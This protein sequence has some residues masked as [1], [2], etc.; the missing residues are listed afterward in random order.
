MHAPGLLADVASSRRSYE[1]ATGVKI[2]NQ[3]ERDQITEWAKQ[4]EQAPTPPPEQQPA[5]A[6]PQEAQHGQTPETQ[7]VQGQQAQ[8]TANEGGEERQGVLTPAAQPGAAEPQPAAPEKPAE[9]PPP[10]KTPLA[11]SKEAPRAQGQQ[12]AAAGK[13]TPEAVKYAPLHELPEAAKL[14]M[15]QWA[16]A[17]LQNEKNP[18]RVKA[19]NKIIEDAGK[20]VGGAVEDMKETLAKQAQGYKAPLRRDKGPGQQGRGGYKEPEDNRD[21][22]GAAVMADPDTRDQMLDKSIAAVRAGQSDPLADRIKELLGTPLH[23]TQDHIDDINSLRD[24]GHTEANPEESFLQPTPQGKPSKTQFPDYGKQ[25]QKTMLSRG[26]IPG[27]QD[28]FNT[29][30][31]EPEREPASDAPS[32]YI[33]GVSPLPPGTQASVIPIPPGVEKDL[34]AAAGVLAKVWDAVRATFS[35]TGI[36]AESKGMAGIV[37]ENAA[38][39]SKQH[40]QARFALGKFSKALMKMPTL[41]RYKFIDS[42]ETGSKIANPNMQKAADSIRNLLDEARDRVR[43]LGTG[44]LD[45]FITNYFP[46]IWK[47]PAKAQQVFGVGKRPLEGSKAFLKKRTIPTTRDGLAAGLEPITDN[48]IDL[49]LLKLHEVN[50]YVMAQKILAE[51][52]AAGY[53]KL[54]RSPGRQPDGWVQIDDKI[55]HVFQRQPTTT[56]SGKQGAPQY[57]HRGDY[58]AHPDAGRILNNY[59]SPGLRG[60][61]VYDAIRFAGNAMNMAQLGLSAFHVTG[62]TINSIVSRTGL[63]AK[64]AFEGNPV[65]GLAMAGKAWIAPVDALIG[66]SRVIREALQPGSQGQDFAQIVDALQAGGHRLGQDRMYRLGEEADT[67]WKGF[68][69]KLKEGRPSAIPAAFLAALEQSSRPMM[70]W[71]IPRMKQGVMLDMA[72]YELSKMPSNATRTDLR[73]TMREVVDSVDNRLGQLIYDNLFWN[74]TMKDVLMIST[75]S[76][77]WNLGTLRELAGGARDI[78]KMGTNLIQGKRPEL[79]HAASYAIALPFVVGILGAGMNYLYTGHGPQ[80]LMDLYHVPTGQKDSKGQDEK[81]Q[82]PTYM[83]DA[84]SWTSNFG[85]TLLS[86]THPLVAATVQALNNKDFYFHPIMNDKDPAVQQAIELAEYVGKQFVPF[87]I[88]NMLERPGKKGKIAREGTLGEKVESFIGITP[89]AQEKGK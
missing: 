50:R 39:L 19:L 9:P 56:A 69:N 23:D 57:V 81:V 35:P 54:F 33:P 10:K 55:G 2:S 47:D 51:G 34:N 78:A 66:G 29:E 84:F 14:A 15:Q 74:K 24:E 67:H 77:G 12:D 63:A 53:V 76:L 18:A 61:G 42:V 36:S 20:D 83:R 52:K 8:Q 16:Q 3:T 87:S 37:R 13:I 64:M 40:E 44:K 45:N 68:L 21:P 25:T 38:V 28:L 31:S 17:R 75:R 4:Q 72:R 82:L 48:P 80:A 88:T 43:A 49:V 27:Q 65:K 60:H 58:Y 26:G 46:H 41:D 22:I 86:K 1:K 32:D 73:E 7:D 59:L 5:A 11:S 62:T 71:Y 85:K 79:T 89:V 6:Q 70:E 30:G